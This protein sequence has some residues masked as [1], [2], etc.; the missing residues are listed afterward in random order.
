MRA[1]LTLAAALGDWKGAAIRASNLSDLHV[2]LG[3]LTQAADLAGQSV[4]L[5]DRS[6]DAAWRT[7]SRTALAYALHQS[8]LAKAKS[9]FRQAEQMQNELQ[10]ECPLLYS[11]QGFQ[12]CDLLLGECEALDHE[13]AVTRCQEVRQRAAQ[14]LD[15]WESVFVNASLL[16][17]ALDH[18]TL[19]RAFLLEAV[20]DGQATALLS[21]AKGHLDR[22]VTGLRQ[23]GAQEFIARGLI[24]RAQ[25]RRV[26]KRFQDAQQDLDEADRIASRGPMRLFQADIHLERARLHQGNPGQSREHLAQAKAIIEETGYLR[27]DSEVK[28]L[29]GQ[30]A[31]R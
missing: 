11:V 5:A 15:W 26:Q 10:P 17:L 24:A 31:S 13:E 25:L 21:E 29:E 22:A 9:L 18:L 19:G 27:R 30:L 8:G 6:G 12:Y 16:T 7:I 1:S 23:A 4:E 28:A 20:L 3:D 14:T 2:I